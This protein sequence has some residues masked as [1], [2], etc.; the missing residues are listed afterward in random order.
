M[1]EIESLFGKNEDVVEVGG[2]FI[3]VA[4]WF[5][6]AIEGGLALA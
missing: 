3:A 5:S 4:M 1:F 2:S 6:D